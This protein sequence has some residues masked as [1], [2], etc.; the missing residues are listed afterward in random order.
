MPVLPWVTFP[1]LGRAPEVQRSRG[2]NQTQNPAPPQSG[3]RSKTRQQHE[4]GAKSLSSTSGIPG[5]RIFPES[6]QNPRGNSWFLKRTTVEKN[7]ESTPRSM[8]TGWTSTPG[9][10]KTQKPS[11]FAPRPRAQSKYLDPPMG[12]CNP[13]SW[14]NSPSLWFFQVQVRQT[15]SY[16]QSLLEGGNATHIGIE[17]SEADDFSGSPI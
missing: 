6:H 14:V 11:F 2:L 10:R 9:R 7:G 3:A 1:K 5:I 15:S 16:K 8:S 13:K 4:P 12:Y 17:R